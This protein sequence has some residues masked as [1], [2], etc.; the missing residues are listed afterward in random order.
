[1][2]ITNLTDAP[3]R[4]LVRDDALQTAMAGTLD[5]KRVATGDLTKFREPFT[6]FTGDP[7][8]NS[9]S[10]FNYPP[11]KANTEITVTNLKV[12]WVMQIR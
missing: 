7:R 8:L 10:H 5:P 3:I 2:Q 6:L 4:F 11:L 1:M 9:T 12:E